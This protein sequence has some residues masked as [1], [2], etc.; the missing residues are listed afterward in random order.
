MEGSDVIKL[1]QKLNIADDGMF[2]A[3]TNKAVK[4][5]Q[6]KKSLTA[7]GIVGSKTWQALG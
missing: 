3:D 5:F 7:D 1:Q 6:Q 2:G 4:E